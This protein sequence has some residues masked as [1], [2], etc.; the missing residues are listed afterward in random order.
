MKFTL[1]WL[2]EHLDTTAPLEEITFALTDLGLEVEGVTNPAARL[3]AFT[4]GEIL[5]ATPHPD[6]DRLR[7]CRVLTAAGETQI[8]CGAPNARAGIKVVVSKPGDYIP[9]IDTTIKVGKIR[10]VESHGMMLS[11]R[12]MELSDAHTG[13]VELDPAVPVG[14]RYI[15][16]RTFDPVI[17]IA[18]TPNRPD[19]LGV[20][21]IARDLAARGLGRLV[22]PA[23]EPIP[24]AFPCPVAVYL[25]PDV[26][27]EACPLFVG[28][29]IRGVRNGPSPQWLQDRLR[30]IGLR[31]ISALVDITNFLTYDRNRPLHVF[32]ADKLNGPLTVRLARPGETIRTLDGKDYAFDGTETVIADSTGADSIGGIKG[33]LRTSA[34]EATTS[35]FVE[36][37]WFDPVRTARTGRRLNAPS[38]ARYRFERGVDP[39]FTP[40]G[41]ELATRLV[42]EICGGEAS[43]LEI[44][45]AIPATTR[46]YRF[47][48]ARVVRLVGMEISAA[49][50][51]RI[52]DA[53][54]F[55]VEGDAAIPPSWRPDVLGDADLVEEIA[56]VASLSRLEGKPL[57]RPA[58][59][60]RPILAPMQRRERDTRRRIAALGLNEC[61]T[62]SFID[63]TAAELF[64][65]GSDAVRLENPISSEMSH[66]RPDLLPGLLRAAARNQ[67]RG[68]ADLALFEIGPVFPGGE[69]GEQ[70]LVAT[71]LRIGATAPR[72][73]MATRR[74][75]DLWDAKR[76][77]EAALAAAGAPASLMVRR[78]VPGWFHPGRSAILLL[79]PKTEL[80]VFG[81]L[82]P[83]VLAA[84]DVKG[85]AVAFS[86]RLEAIPFP[87]ARTATRPPLVA[88]D[89]QPVERDF[90]FVL[91]ERVEA[92]AVLKA[93][94]AADK[95]LIDAVSVFDVF[96]GP[97]AE[98]Q[99]GTGKKSVAVSVRLQ[100]TDRT[101]TDAEIEAVAAKIV[102]SVAKATGGNLRT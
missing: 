77:A 14:A 50:Q 4:V 32:D 12:E 63:R 102:A 24:G 87:K 64:G 69:P 38:D 89:F 73:P 100:P 16:V 2:K 58:G 47:D 42:L 83:R 1:A 46:R 90:A 60:A 59:V 11:E 94:R 35:V 21:G 8:V 39:A 71:G 99:M 92:E 86:V 23:I 25:A 93:A 6:A 55:T 10:G 91:D 54:G 52:L 78:D 7:V 20:A 51:V 43:D 67:A 29:L 22:T 76:D 88:S 37:A 101:L 3:A 48:P 18:V 15:D 74:P 62:Y 97:T 82:H 72:N 45:G 41:L 53:L 66:L 34:T 85:P 33:G 31:P 30:A 70:T 57:A 36:A 80:A 28:R 26:A 95:T 98:A 68:F 9:G 5:E 27:T 44:A 65:G 96:A 56:R 49:E 19:A 40:V 75:V 81:E 84:L 79:G 17:E 13:I 61:V